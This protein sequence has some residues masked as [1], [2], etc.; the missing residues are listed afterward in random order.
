MKRIAILVSSLWIAF[1]GAAASA[2]VQQG[3]YV[4]KDS[5][6]ILF[7]KCRV[8]IW[9]QSTGDFTVVAVHSGNLTYNIWMRPQIVLVASK[10]PLVVT[11]STALDYQDAYGD[12][13][14]DNLLSDDQSPEPTTL[15]IESNEAGM[16]TLVKLEGRKTL[17]CGKFT[18][19]Y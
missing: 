1:A 2:D 10:N 8:E 9:K 7:N 6:L 12:Y 17:N 16:P 13:I 5:N 4:G 11:T 15:T 19:T 14:F 18:K 3:L